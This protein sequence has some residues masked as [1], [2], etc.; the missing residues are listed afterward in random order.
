MRNRVVMLPQMAGLD[1]SPRW[2]HGRL[3]FFGWAAAI[4]ADLTT[5]ARLPRQGAPVAFGQQD[6][7]ACWRNSGNWNAS[8]QS[9]PDIG[10]RRPN[11]RLAGRRGL[12]SLIGPPGQAVPPPVLATWSSREEIVSA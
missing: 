11:N 5:Y 7:P 8:N 4:R 10:E 6:K 12:G 3:W 9:E 1:E 2:H